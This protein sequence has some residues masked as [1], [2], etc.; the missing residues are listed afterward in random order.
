MKIKKIKDV[1][2]PTRGTSKSA[3]FDF[4]IPNDFNLGENFNLLPQKSINIPSG[5][6]CEVP[7]GYALIK[8]E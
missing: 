8:V 2:T 4:Y 3:G 1:K 6:I 7:D 5:I